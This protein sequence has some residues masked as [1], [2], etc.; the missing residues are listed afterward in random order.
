VTYRL[1]IRPDALADIE[2]AADWY[3]EKEPGLGNEFARE[4]LHAI[5]TLPLNP[6][7]YR[8][9]HRRGNVRWK[10]MRT[11]PYRIVYRITDHLITVFAVLHAARQERHWRKRL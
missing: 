5:D 6:L 11:F 1:E 7:L 4:V 3:D 9:R 2:N 10:L 8:V